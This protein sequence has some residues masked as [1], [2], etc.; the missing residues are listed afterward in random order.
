MRGTRIWLAS[1]AAAVAM[2]GLTACGSADKAA[3]AA[4][5]GGAGGPAVA[6]AAATDLTAES[7]AL[8]AAG[9]DVAELPGAPGE[10][11]PNP[12]G[13]P[14]AKKGDR[15]GHPGPEGALLRK[16]VL[17]GELVVKNK[18]GE[19]KTV[20]VQRGEVTAIDDKSITVKSSDGF[21]LTWTFGKELKVVQGRDPYPRGNIK[22]GTEVGVA[23]VKD[24]S[25]VTARLIVVPKKQ[26]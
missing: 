8:A 15:P 21:T 5:A 20:A 26:D 23:G 1:A 11:N 9:F 10:P 3:D 2:L 18:E 24:G 25:T 16:A 12:S 6:A 17:H 7:E 19:V 14:G 4:S 22:V 13:S